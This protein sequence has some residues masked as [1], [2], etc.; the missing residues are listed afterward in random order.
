MSAATSDRSPEVEAKPSASKLARYSDC[1]GSFNLE[2]S[3]PTGESSAAA[4]LGT[5][6]HAHLAGEKV[7][8]CEEGAQIAERCREQYLE[9]RE[10]IIGDRYAG[11]P[12]KEERFW[13]R[14]EWSGAIDRIDFFYDEQGEYALITDYKSGRGVVEDAAANLQLRAYAVLVS[15]AFPRLTA[16]YAAVIQP[17]AGKP[18]VTV[19]GEEEITQARAEI[20]GIIAA[21]LKPDA[22]RRPSPEA[23]KYCRA[24]AICPE[25][26]RETKALATR[27]AADVP[28]LPALELSQLLSASTV[29]EDFISAIKDEAKARLKAGKEVPGWTLIQKKGAVR[30]DSKALKIRWSELTSEPIPTVTGE[31]SVMLK[32]SA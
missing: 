5:Q 24:L 26:A 16:I 6:V 17:H 10:R 14:G 25:A 29:V 9:I 13:Y 30:T 8:L 11:A 23:C 7:E 31:P 12:C 21:T 28:A 20:N 32:K 27:S 22:P 4:N 19:Y 2:V 1:P 3:L 18:T 15:E